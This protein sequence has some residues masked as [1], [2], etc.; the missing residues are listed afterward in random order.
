MNRTATFCKRALPLLTTAHLSGEIER[1]S[2][3]VWD[4]VSSQRS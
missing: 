1:V 2:K 4:W 3:Y